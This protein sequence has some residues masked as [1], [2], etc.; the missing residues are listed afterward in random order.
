MQKKREE[1]GEKKKEE[2]ENEEVKQEGEEQKGEADRG[3]GKRRSRR[4]MIKEGQGST[5]EERRR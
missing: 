2:G 1:E 3:G 4:S 5:G